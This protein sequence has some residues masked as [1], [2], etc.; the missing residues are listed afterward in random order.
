MKITLIAYILLS[1]YSLAC[2]S[3]EDWEK[4][5]YKFT[6]DGITIYSYGKFDLPDYNRNLPRDVKALGSGEILKLAD[7]YLANTYGKKFRPLVTNICLLRKV[8]KDKK[9]YWI[10]RLRYLSSNSTKI[11][12]EGVTFTVFLSPSGE[13]LMKKYAETTKK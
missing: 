1:F 7:Q 9:S 13:V 11:P 2:E 3:S 12:E 6:H 8:T 5:P 4:A 10:W